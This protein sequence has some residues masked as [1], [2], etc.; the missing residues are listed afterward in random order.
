M[1]ARSAAPDTAQGRAIQAVNERWGDHNTTPNGSTG[2]GTGTNTTST[3][4]SDAPAR[5]WLTR[6]HRKKG[7]EAIGI[8]VCKKKYKPFQFEVVTDDTTGRVQV[9]LVERLYGCRCHHPQRK[10]VIE[11]Y[12]VRN[13]WQPFGVWS[14]AKALA[15]ARR[16]TERL[17][18][19][20]EEAVAAATEQELS[21]SSDDDDEQEDKAPACSAGSMACGMRATA[22]SSKNVTTISAAAAAKRKPCRAMCLNGNCTWKVRSAYDNIYKEI[23][24]ESEDE[25]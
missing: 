19:E 11:R 15:Q 1:F 3:N 24:G 23:H 6:R 5:Q 2:S 4:S 9:V 13:G 8:P 10:R 16:E 12:G 18:R 25:G 17:N 20:H 14:R 21:S 22:K 7:R